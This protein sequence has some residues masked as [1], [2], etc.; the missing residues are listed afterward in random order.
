MVSGSGR[1]AHPNRH[2]LRLQ[3]LEAV[4]EGEG[5]IRIGIAAAVAVVDFDYT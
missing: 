1:A 4:E 3:R 2:S 5:V